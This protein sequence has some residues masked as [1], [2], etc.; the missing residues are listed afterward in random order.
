MSIPK[1]LPHDASI[2]AA[3]EVLEDAHVHMVLLTRGGELVGTI[4]RDDLPDDCRSPGPALS[5]AVLQGRT[6]A[7][8]ETVAE[9]RGRMLARKQ[10]RLA[11]VDDDHQLLGLL[12]LKRDHSGFCSDQGVRARAAERSAT[13]PHQFEGKSR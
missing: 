2:E 12:C 7:P 4:T 1:T 3:R 5:I 8:T 13:Q 9:V 11:V 6:V 10:R